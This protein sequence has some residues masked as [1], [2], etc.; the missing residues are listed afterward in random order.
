MLVAL[1]DDS[2]ASELNGADR[3]NPVS[4]LDGILFIHV[5][6]MR[7][8]RLH[9]RLATVIRHPDRRRP[10]LGG[11]SRRHG[12]HGEQHSAGPNQVPRGCRVR[13]RFGQDRGKTTVEVEAEFF[14]RV[15]PTSLIKRF[16][17]VEEVAS[18]VT[19]IASPLA[20]ATTGA[21]LRVDGGVVKSAF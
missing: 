4:H 13:R 8:D 2:F 19:Y 10:G 14:D 5:K 15:R 3:P 7:H 9:N 11:I 17:T 18:L 20:S 6:E 12:Y 1:Y 21:A 16:A